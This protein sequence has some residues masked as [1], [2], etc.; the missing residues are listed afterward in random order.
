VTRSDLIKARLHALGL[1][2]ERERVLRLPGERL[3][4]AP[5]S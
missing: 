5:R 3:W 4:G 1:E 2:Q